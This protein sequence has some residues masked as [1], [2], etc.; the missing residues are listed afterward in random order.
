MIKQQDIVIVANRLPVTQE[1]DNDG[2]SQWVTSPGGLVA[3]L[4]PAMAGEKVAWLGWTGG[5]DQIEAPFDHDGIHLVPVPLSPDERELHYDGMANG[6]FWPLYHDKIVPAE[7]HRH[8]YDGHRRVNRRF[9][10]AAAEAAA[11][12]ATVWVHDYQLQLVPGML[13]ELRPEDRFNIIE[14]N[15][16]HRALYR[17]P[18]PATRHHARPARPAL[19]RWVWTS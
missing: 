6:T 4:K 11:T 2:N 10:I 15:S 18:V 7:F 9:A 14:F 1:V 12:G 16:T 8:W 5:L 13:R 17:R 3:A 19:Q